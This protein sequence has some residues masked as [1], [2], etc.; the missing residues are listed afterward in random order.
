MSATESHIPGVAAA[1]VT[2]DWRLSLSQCRK[3]MSEVAPQ[4]VVIRMTE[5]IEHAPATCILLK[6]ANVEQDKLGLSC[7]E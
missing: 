3:Q 4:E 5:K 6:A 2:V 1:S 7:C